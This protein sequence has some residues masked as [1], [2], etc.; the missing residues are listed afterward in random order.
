MAKTKVYLDM[1]KK[2]GTYGLGVLARRLSSVLLLPLYTRL[3]TPAD[4]GILDLLDLTLHMVTIFVGMRLGEAVLYFHAH[5]ETDEE[6]ERTLG[7]AFL[8]AC[9][10]G[11][12]VGVLGA[13]LAPQWS[14]LILGSDRYPHL[15]RLTFANIAVSFPIE[16]GLS[17]VRTLN[18]AKLFVTLST[19]R[20]FTMMGLN[21][22]MLVGLRMG[23]ES[24]LWS[25]VIANTG[26]A[27]WLAWFCFR[28]KRPTFSLARLRE[29]ARYSMPLAVHGIAMLAIH[30]GDR[31]FLRQ[32]VSLAD[33]GVYA[34]AY[35][36]GM[37]ISYVQT[38]FEYYWRSQVF[39]VARGEDGDWLYVRTCTY[40]TLVLTTVAVLL[41][42]F[43]DPVARILVGGNFQGVGLYVP[44]LAAGYVLR[45]L[46]DYFRNA[47]RMKA[48]TGR[49]A[50][51]TLI[52]SACC[53]VCYAVLIPPFKVAGAVAATVIA[54]G[55]MVVLSYRAAQQVKPYH[56]ELDRL[57]KI[58]ACAAAVVAAFLAV[59]PSPLA[60][61]FGVASAF[62]LSFPL[63]LWVSGFFAADERRALQGA[64]R[65]LRHQAFAA[66]WQT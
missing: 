51:V 61:Q 42:L 4:Y 44:G 38:P 36:L 8:G 50:K 19:T 57:V 22:I 33:L 30:Y 47:I 24:M 49:E 16:I 18:R 14:A 56:F 17:Y 40:L 13:L 53:L 27:A 65:K 66:R 45:A 59:K 12:A 46:S 34:L 23:V 5:A 7:T 58:F 26:L 64:F 60:V 21:V 63:L 2:S 37:L 20:L 39:H 54:F 43:L 9:A 62:A 28:H 6:K 52:S 10:I 31:L 11:A 25:N 48:H 32:H 3:L 15:V 41:V 55:L 1:L 35:K 29:Q